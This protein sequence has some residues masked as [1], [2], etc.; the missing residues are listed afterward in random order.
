MAKWEKICP[1]DEVPAQSRKLLTLGVWNVLLFNTGKRYFA[2]SAECPHLGES[3]ELG[4]LQGIII[5]CNAHGYQMNLTDGKCLTE[6]G[7][8]LPTFPVEVREG[9]IWIKI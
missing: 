4:E 2:S 9:W 5:R 1:V 3:L 6:A 8:N 7:L